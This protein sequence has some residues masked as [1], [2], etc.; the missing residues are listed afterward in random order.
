MSYALFNRGEQF[1]RESF[2]I[3]AAWVAV[4][5]LLFFVGLFLHNRKRVPKSV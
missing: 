5:L 4:V 3:L 1:V 2:L